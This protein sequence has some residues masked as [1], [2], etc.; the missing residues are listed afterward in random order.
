[1]KSEALNF[2]RRLG[3]LFPSL[4]F[5]SVYCERIAT[6]KADG[7]RPFFFPHFPSSASTAVRAELSADTSFLSPLL[8]L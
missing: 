1:M 4:P 5:F 8:S 3:L 2:L 6:I 7:R